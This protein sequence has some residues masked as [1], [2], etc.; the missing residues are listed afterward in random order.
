VAAPPPIAVQVFYDDVRGAVAWLC[1]TFGFEEAWTL[2]GP[3]DTLLMASLTTPGGGSVMVSGAPDAG[4]ALS[5]NPYYSVT[6]LVP[7]VDAHA[8]RARA[9]GAQLVTEPTSQPWGYRDYEVLD[10]A[11]RQWNFSQVLHDAQPEDW[12]ASSR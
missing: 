12:G 4:A 8:E 6:V 10:V 9:A 1:R 5:P 11:G 7:D 2:D 3:S